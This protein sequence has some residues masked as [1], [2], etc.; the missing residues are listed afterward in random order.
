[1]RNVFSLFAL[2]ICFESI[3]TELGRSGL[4]RQSS[5]ARR[6][7]WGSWSSGEETSSSEAPQK[8]YFRYFHFF[9]PWKITN[10]T[11][12]N[13][14]EISFANIV[15]FSIFT[16][17]TFRRAKRDDNHFQC[18][19]LWLWP[20]MPKYTWT[21]KLTTLNLRQNANFVQLLP[22]WNSLLALKLIWR[23]ILKRYTDMWHLR[24]LLLPLI[25]FLC[26]AHF[27]DLLPSLVRMPPLIRLFIW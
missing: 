2:F 11:N 3:R 18:A 26:I 17:K 8:S 5:G 4:R 1:M 6:R 10:P 9:S 24:K 19:S 13:S 12:L 14:S 7:N 23:N 20:S 25:R 16:F 27:K 22:S 15:C 21:F